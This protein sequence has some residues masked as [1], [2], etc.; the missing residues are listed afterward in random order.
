MA[1]RSP[2]ASPLDRANDTP[3]PPGSGSVF[4]FR[5][6]S[7]GRWSQQARIERFQVSANFGDPFA[8]SGDGDT[9]AVGAY[10]QGGEAGG[11]NPPEVEVA[12]DRSG[13][14]H[15][16]IRDVQGQWTRQ[17]FIKAA[18]PIPDEDWHQR[19]AERRWQ[20]HACR[21]SPSPAAVR[22]RSRAMAAGRIFTGV[23]VEYA[24]GGGGM[25]LS[26]DGRSIAV[27]AFGTEPGGNPFGYLAVHVL[28]E[29]TTLGEG[30]QG[31][32]ICGRAARTGGFD[33]TRKW[34]TRS[35][36]AF[37]SA[38]AV[39]RLRSAHTWTPATR[40]TRATHPISDRRRRERSMS[41][42]PTATARGNG[43]RSSRR[44]LLHGGSAGQQVAMSS[45]GS[46]V[47]AK[48][49]GL[50]ANAVG[51]RRNHSDGAT[52][53]L[54][55]GERAC[56]IWG[57]ARISSNA[58]TGSGRTPRRRSQRPVSWCHTSSFRWQSAATDRQ[59]AWVQ[60]PAGGGRVVVY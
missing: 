17:A 16:Y 41:L 19:G 8:L 56:R 46:V 5:R 24:G 7:D 59:S 45:D 30:W 20:P 31:W 55:E 28:R 53:G 50:A 54:E 27:R 42:R 32:P 4:V 36:P 44:R 58:V 14:V 25:A 1:T 13:A 22:P 35:A 34:T 51:L 57:A 18:D 3:D 29:V 33:R 11:I 43:T 2:P 10:T 15:V 9:L 23:G 48:A 21:C 39:R 60:M 49:C 26:G 12:A 47:A 52:I 38:T 6:A 37:H 40:T